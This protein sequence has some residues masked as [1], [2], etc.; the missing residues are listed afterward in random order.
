MSRLSVTSSVNSC[1]V[2]QLLLTMV[3]TRREKSSEN[4]FSIETLTAM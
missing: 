4:R 2:L 1:G 3:P